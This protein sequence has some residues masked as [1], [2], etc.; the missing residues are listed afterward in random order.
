ML[1]YPANPI[2][3]C[4]NI[5]HENRFRM[6]SGGTDSIN[7]NQF[8]SGRKR[9]VWARVEEKKERCAR[10]EIHEKQNNAPTFSGVEILFLSKSLYFF[11]PPQSS[12][13]P[14]IPGIWYVIIPAIRKRKMTFE[15]RENEEEKKKVDEV[16][17]FLEI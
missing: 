5:S 15:I 8:A 7:I 13:V 9:R 10:N 16:S 14:A 2:P 3:R 4:C 6:H 11:F 12:P 1:F 17:P